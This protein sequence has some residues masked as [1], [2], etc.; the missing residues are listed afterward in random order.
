[1]SEQ[2]IDLNH[3]EKNAFAAKL[4]DTLLSKSADELPKVV[5]VPSGY[6]LEHTE[7]FKT[8]RNRFSGSLE[9][10]SIEE[11]AEYIKDQDLKE[12][13]ASCFIDG[14]ALTAKAILDLGTIESP[15]H[16]VH[17]ANLVL[18][19]TP[20]Y[21]FLLDALNDRKM[22][23]KRTAELLEEWCDSISAVD[24]EGE[25]MSAKQLVQSIRKIS[26]EK[27]S[28]KES[29]VSQ[30]SENMSALEK[31]EAKNKERM[32][33]M[34]FFKCRPTEDL[35]ERTFNLRLSIIADGEKPVLVMRVQQLAV[36][37]KHIAEEFKGLAKQALSETSVKTYVG[38]GKF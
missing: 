3:V 20:E 7:K 5:V 10:A 34:V 18:E 33:S 28:S 9:T 22:N 26:I 1:M 11:W 38:A 19:R 4:H 21:E 2:L 27:S 23:Q 36:I 25:D 35:M 16:C 29:E 37:K 12:H 14:D 30:Y 8:N 31:I 15:G 32:P 6:S 17:K 13:A 24:E